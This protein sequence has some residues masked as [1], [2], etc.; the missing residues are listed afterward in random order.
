MLPS[1]LRDLLQRLFFLLFVRPFTLLFMGLRVRGLE[2]LPHRDPFVLI[3]NHSSHLDTIVLLS[4]FR[5]SRLRRIRPCA[6]ADYWEA[7]PL[8]SALSRALFNILPIARAR[9][10]PE[11]H[12]IHRMS[13]ALDRG[14]SLILF[15]EGTR[16]GGDEVAPFKAGIARLL[17]ERPDVPVVPAY[18]VNLGRS[19]PK[20][21]WIPLPFFCEA[22]LGAP[23]KPAGGRDQ[24]LA[25]LQAAVLRLREQP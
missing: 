25:E 21:E 23:L 17:E 22:R 6:A 15:P 19:L 24:V 13:E 1:D 18:L 8:R 3:A 5:L 20:G 12:P 4:L 10:T 7:T 16:G 9:F 11:N 2:H 14:E